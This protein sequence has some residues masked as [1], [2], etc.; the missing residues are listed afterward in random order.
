M[1]TFQE[2]EQ[3]FEAK[4][5]HDEEF[6]YLVIARRDKLFA[7]WAAEQLGLSG[8]DRADLTV[9]VLGVRDG[10]GHD[11]LLVE[12]VSKTFAQHGTG[13]PMVGLAPVLQRFAIEAR[14]QLLD[15]EPAQ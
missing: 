9:S 2:R 4:Y 8:R 15:G 10:Q 11:E 13:V 5:A 1:T 3:A 7:A 6:R 14:Q 12:H